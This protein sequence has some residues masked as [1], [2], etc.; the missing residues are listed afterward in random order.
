[1]KLHAKNIAVAAGA[2][3][4]L[5]DIVSEAMYKQSNINL[6]RAKAILHELQDRM[7]HST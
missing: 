4:A 2:S 6:D 7:E 1:M 3:G 5:V